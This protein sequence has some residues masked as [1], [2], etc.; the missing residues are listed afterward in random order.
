MV[1]GILCVFSQAANRPIYTISDGR[2]AAV[3]SLDVPYEKIR[4]E[5]R[6]LAVHQ[7]V[8][9]RL[10][11]ES[12]VIAG[13]IKVKLVDIELLSLQIRLVICSVD[14]AKEMGMDWWVNNPVS[15]SG[16]QQGERPDSLTEIE[17][18]LAKLE[19]LVAT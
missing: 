4:P 16:A 10:M 3:V 9:K 19:A 15:N 12:I 13:D 7:G 14:K 11:Q 17:E 8:L 6:H 5:R 18:R 2:V 1:V